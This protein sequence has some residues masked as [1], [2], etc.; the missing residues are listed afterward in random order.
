MLCM[1]G[2]KVSN[3]GIGILKQIWL[4]TIVHIKL[5]LFHAY[6]VVLGAI[7]SW[8]MFTRKQQYWNWIWLYLTP[9]IVVPSETMVEITNGMVSDTYFAL[10]QFGWQFVSWKIAMHISSMRISICKNWCLPLR[11]S[12]VLLRIRRSNNELEVW[13]MKHQQNNRRVLCTKKPF[14]VVTCISYC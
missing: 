7:L 11:S 8:Y 5:H 9:C 1:S 4:S 2:Y 14:S 6:V 3:I 10:L 13:K 12:S